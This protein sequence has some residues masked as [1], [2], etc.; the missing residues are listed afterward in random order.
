MRV[1]VEEGEECY[2]TAKELAESGV[3][4]YLVI[5]LAM[6]N[7]LLRQQKNFQ[8]FNLDM[9]QVPKLILKNYLITIMHL[10]QFMKEGILLALLLV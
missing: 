3:K 7:T 4:E 5:H 9:L 6:K 10:L 1:N 2:K 8:K